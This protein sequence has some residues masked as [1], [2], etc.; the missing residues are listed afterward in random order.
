MKTLP[1]LLSHPQ[2]HITDVIPRQAV[3]DNILY[4]TYKYTN[5]VKFGINCE[6]I[7]LWLPGSPCGKFR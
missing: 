2:L 3:S 6:Q 5:F 4:T 1:I 7:K